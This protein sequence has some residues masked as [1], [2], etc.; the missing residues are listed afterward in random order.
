MEPGKELYLLKISFVFI[1]IES[2]IATLSYFFIFFF[3]SLNYENMVYI[4]Y[5]TFGKCQDT[6]T[7]FGIYLVMIYIERLP[8]LSFFICFYWSIN[9]MSQVSKFHDFFWHA[10]KLKR[11]VFESLYFCHLWKVQ[12]QL[13]STFLKRFKSFF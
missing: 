9:C 1:L 6:Q 13:S 3:W 4:L 2:S 5:V 8:R 10:Q 12:F 11:F 7:L